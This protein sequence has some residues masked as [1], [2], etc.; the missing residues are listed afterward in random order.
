MSSFVVIPDKISLHLG[1]CSGVRVFN[2]WF[3][4]LNFDLWTRG[5]DHCI[6]CIDMNKTVKKQDNSISQ[7]VIHDLKSFNPKCCYV[8]RPTYLWSYFSKTLTCLINRW[9]IERKKVQMGPISPWVFSHH[10]PC[11]PH[12]DDLLPAQKRSEPCKMKNL[13][14]SFYL[15]KTAY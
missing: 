7:P 5:S 14:A 15:A 13:K 11:S 6:T 2:C 1:D 4:S 9:V 12:L 10:F 3:Q 8:Y